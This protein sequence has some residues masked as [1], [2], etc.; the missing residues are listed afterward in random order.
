[1]SAAVMAL[2][3][4]GAAAQSSSPAKP[5]QKT[6]KECVKK[7]VE[8]KGTDCVT[9]HANCKAPKNKQCGAC[10]RATA[11]KKVVCDSCNHN[12]IKGECT[13]LK[14]ECSKTNAKATKIK[15]R[16]TAKQ[17]KTLKK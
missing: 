4:M 13:K 3:T 15:A 1:M 11:A 12:H 8:C 5:A 16:K 9:N 7:N 17:A 6:V 10:R 14:A 2:M